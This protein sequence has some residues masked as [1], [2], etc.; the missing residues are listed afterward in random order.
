MNYITLDKEILHI[1]QVMG[2]KACE[3]LEEL[4]PNEDRVLYKSVGYSSIVD[5]IICM[6]NYRYNKTITEHQARDLW[7]EFIGLDCKV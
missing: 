5:T 1:A 7:N 6:Y 4:L 3:Y 2:N